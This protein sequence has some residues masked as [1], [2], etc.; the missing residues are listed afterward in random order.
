MT[1]YFTI[2][3]T[4]FKQESKT[5]VNSL[6]SV[7]SFIVII[8]IFK[9]LWDFIYGKN[10]GGQLIN[11]YT[12]EMMIWY[13]IMAEI[14]MYSLNA[15]RVTS[16]FSKDIKT[17]RIAYQLNKPYNYFFYQI[18]HH[19]GEILWKLIFLI[20][21][22]LAMGL[23]LLGPIANF[24]A[25]YIAPILVSLLLA[26]FLSC[27]IYGSIGLLSFWIEE[28]TP[29]TW[30]IQ[31]L[32]MLLG[33][34]FPPEFFPL[35]LQ[36]I[37]NYSPVFAMMSGPCKLLADFS[38]DLFLKVSISQVAWLAIFTALGLI[39]YRLGTRK[40]TNNGG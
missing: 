39:I 20:P 12:L 23:L 15:R 33:L 30:I 2:F 37:I 18:S 26:A 9:Q 8:F 28:A 10:G 19:A 40:V 16:D 14:L 24:S 38:W 4:S 7:L 5:L 36:P 29:F 27:V 3:K 31:K 17:G 13:M 6:L 1:K 25:A 11:G 32:Q 34:F 21:A 35:W 22:A